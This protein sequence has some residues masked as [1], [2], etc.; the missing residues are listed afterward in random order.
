MHASLKS[1][2]RGQF[3][4]TDEVGGSF[5]LIQLKDDG[6]IVEDNMVPV[7]HSGGAGG[8]QLPSKEENIYTG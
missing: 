2:S 8:L 5:N 6:Q 7:G 4:P 1:D 3:D